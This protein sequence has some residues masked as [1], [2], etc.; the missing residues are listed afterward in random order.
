VAV[1]S[2]RLAERLPEMTLS[3]VSSL[4]TASGETIR[5]TAPRSLDAATLH[6]MLAAYGLDAATGPIEWADTLA[7]A[8]ALLKFGVAD[9]AIVDNLQETLTLSGFHR[10]TDDLG[11]L[12]STRL[13]MI[14]RRSLLSRFP[15]IGP[16][17]RDLAGRLTDPVLHDLSGRVRLLQ[18]EPEDVARGFLRQEGLLVE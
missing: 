16:L 1:A 17:L 12:E 11:V 7:E 5:Y 6:G 18:L 8:E 2:G 10:L 3:A 14:L 9:V 13:A 4:L 15:D